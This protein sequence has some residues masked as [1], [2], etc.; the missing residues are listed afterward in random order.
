MHFYILIL[1]TF[2]KK[3]PNKQQFSIYFFLESSG[4]I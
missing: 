3:V 1:N 2:K 4:D